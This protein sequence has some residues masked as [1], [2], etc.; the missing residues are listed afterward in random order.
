MKRRICTSALFIILLA[1]AFISNA[2]TSRQGLLIEVTNAEGRPLKNACVTVIPKE[3]E[4]TFRKADRNGHVKVK[5]L[6]PGNY[7]VVVKVDGYT[8]QKRVVV[9]GSEFETVAFSLQPRSVGEI[10]R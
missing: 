2:Q 3:G 9:V 5:G 4:I 10:S 8:A 6:S 1:C 7:R